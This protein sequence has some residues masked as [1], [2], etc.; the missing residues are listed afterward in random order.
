MEGKA[1]PMGQP[2]QLFK[3]KSLIVEHERFIQLRHLS[4][5]DEYTVLK[6]LGSGSFGS[7]YKVEHKSLKLKRALKVIRN[8]SIGP[9]PTKEEIDVLMKLDHP[10]ILKLYEFYEVKD[11]FFLVT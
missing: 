10:N 6:K 4:F 8:S 5:E 2:R 7:V 11:K 3:K 1:A 9:Y